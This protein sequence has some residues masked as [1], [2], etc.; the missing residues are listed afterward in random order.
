MKKE[1]SE[2]QKKQ[3]RSFGGL[4]L[5]LSLGVIGSMLLWAREYRGPVTEVPQTREADLVSRAASETTQTSG[6]PGK[7]KLSIQDGRPLAQ[8]ILMLQERFGLV[9][10]YEDPR[11]VN[12]DEMS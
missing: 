9:I 4:V 6:A 3:F 12:A 1:H 8:A 10:T 5:L 7:V 2:I 11:Y